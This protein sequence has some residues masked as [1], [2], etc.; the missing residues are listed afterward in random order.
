M[1]NFDTHEAREMIYDEHTDR[2]IAEADAI[3]K[4]D[5]AQRQA[6]PIVQFSD[7]QVQIAYA[8]LVDSEA[9]PPTGEHWEGFAARRI[10]DALRQAGQEPVMI[11][12]GRCV[13]DCG[14]HGHQDVELLKFIPAGAKLYTAPQAAAVEPLTT[15]QYI[16]ALGPVRDEMV[17]SAGTLRRIVRAI[18]AAHG[19]TKE[20]K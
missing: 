12:H 4:A 5:R 19:I 1:K 2:K 8:V 16:Q 18:E 9:A 7:P 20:T 11:Y 14:E 15:E 6:V 10:I 17:C 13:I 3:I